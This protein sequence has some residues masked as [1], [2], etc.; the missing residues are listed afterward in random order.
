MPT[1][2]EI[3]FELTEEAASKNFLILKKYSFDLEK[4]INKQK[5]SL[6]RFRSKFRPSHTFRRIF[7]HHPLWA[8]M[9]HLLINGSEWPLAEISKSN[10]IADF[11]KA[12]QFGN[13]KGAYQK[14]VPL[15]KLISDDI[16]HGYGLVIAWGEISCLPNACLA[17]MIITKQ[18]TLKA[19][20]EIVDKKHLTHDQS[21]KWLSR[22]LVNK[23]V[24]QESLQQCMYGRCLMRLLCWIVAT[25]RKFPNAPIALQKINIKSAYQQCHLN[26]I[27]AMQTITQ[28]PRKDLGIIMLCLTFGGAP[29]PLEWNI[30]SESIRDLANKILFNKNWNPLTNYTP[31]QHLVQAMALLDASIPFEE[32]AKLIVEI[33]VDPQGTKS[34]YIDDLIQAT[35]V[36]DGTD[37]A[38]Q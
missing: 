14:L 6:L 31:S 30:L 34:V 17:P 1:P 28:L 7:Q 19:G 24:I 10:R 26:A 22:L 32:G 3:V 38:I 37:N 15:K 11:T 5:S 12:L 20:R 33:P 21:L 16:R 8:R 18:F 36:M 4:A 27:T 35:V 9:E 13:Q 23:R 2:P 25:R 29:C